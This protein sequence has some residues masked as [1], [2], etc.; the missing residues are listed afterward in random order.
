MLGSQFSL[1][2]KIVFDWWI[3]GA[4][5]GKANG[6]L[7]AN[8]NLTP[9]EQIELKRQLDNIDI[10]FTDTENEVRSNGATIRT[11]GSMA[12]VRGLGFNIGFRF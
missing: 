6:N 2:K 7:I 1:A 5:I 11:T 12:G 3:L 10:P 4:S 9:Q 8:V